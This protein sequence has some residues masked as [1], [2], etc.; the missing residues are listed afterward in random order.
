MNPKKL[1]LCVLLVL[2]LGLPGLQAQYAILAAGSNAS[3]IGGSISYSVGQVVYITMTGTNGSMAPGVQQP[4]EISVGL[5]EAKGITLSC[6][7]YPN[8]VFDVLTLKVEN[9]NHSTLTV[10]LY[11]MNGKVLENKKLEGDATSIDMGNLAPAT[12]FLKVTDNN[13]EVKIFKI[14]KN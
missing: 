14:I 12:Y 9:F 1:K 2:G 6:S 8:P 10:S 11:D 5:D 13:K 7:V 3:G 4:Y